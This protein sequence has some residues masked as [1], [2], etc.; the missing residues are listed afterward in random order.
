MCKLPSGMSF[1]RCKI[2]LGNDRHPRDGEG[3]GEQMLGYA[4]KLEGITLGLMADLE[5]FGFERGNAD[6]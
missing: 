6:E 3:F 2:W 1:G 4:L 5:M